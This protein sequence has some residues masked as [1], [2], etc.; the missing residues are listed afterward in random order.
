MAP[1]PRQPKVYHITHVSNLAR[2]VQSGFI[3]SDAKR[4][5][6]GIDCEVVGLSPI[7]QRRLR[8]P[9]KCHPGLMVGN[10]VPFYFCSRSIMLYILHI[11]NHPDLTYRGGQVPIVHLVSDVQKVVAWAKDQGRRWAFSSCNAGGYLAKFYSDLAN[12]DEIN[13]EAVQAL[14]FRNP[15][16][17]EGKQ[18]E[19]L[20][21]ESFPW[22]LVDTVAVR[23]EGIKQQVKTALNGAG[24]QPDIHVEPD[25]Y[26]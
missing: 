26:F 3:L 19:F 24:H 22:D 10:C 23:D 8:L 9:V 25:W 17:K 20:I 11:G 4:L 1:V 21:D 6:I 7:K 15:D 2:I 14:D 12:L 16:I 18:A 13:W 5:E